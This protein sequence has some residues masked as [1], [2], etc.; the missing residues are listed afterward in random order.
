VDS[1]KTKQCKLCS[2]LPENLVRKMN[3]CTDGKWVY[4][5]HYC[6]LPIDI[7]VPNEINGS[8]LHILMFQGSILDR[9]MVVDFR[10]SLTSSFQYESQN[11]RPAILNAERV[12]RNESFTVI[13]YFVFSF[14]R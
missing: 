14:I 9:E 10:N 6:Y 12:S 7:S 4:R 1:H 8:L 3:L 5:T 11:G 2:S 13:N